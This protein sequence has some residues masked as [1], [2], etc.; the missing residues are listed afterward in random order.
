[1]ELKRQRSVIVPRAYKPYTWAALEM[2]I[3]YQQFLSLANA[4]RVKMKLG[5]VD[6]DL[7]KDHLEA[8]R[9]LASRT[10]P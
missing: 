10:A 6:F 4:K 9:D 5:E 7:N 1:M 2:T 3:P 8:I